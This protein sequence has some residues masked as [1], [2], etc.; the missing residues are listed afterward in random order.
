ML[1]AHSTTERQLAALEASLKVNES[2]CARETATLRNCTDA[3]QTLH[4][5]LRA[6]EENALQQAV[7]TTEQHG[8]TS[9]RVSEPYFSQSHTCAPW[10]RRNDLTPSPTNG[11]VSSRRVLMVGL[12]GWDKWY[13]WADNTPM[14]SPNTGGEDYCTLNTNSYSFSVRVACNS[15]LCRLLTISRQ[16]TE[17]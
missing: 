13:S 5:S 12:T 9:S 6:I 3:L 11:M 4:E 14:A 17:S 15:E 7:A 16:L 10:L 2:S 8:S 1:S